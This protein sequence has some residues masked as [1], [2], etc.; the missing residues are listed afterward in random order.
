MRLKLDEENLKQIN[1][2]LQAEYTEHKNRLEK[3]ITESEQY[4]QQVSQRQ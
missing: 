1:L 4:E 2:Q 3:I